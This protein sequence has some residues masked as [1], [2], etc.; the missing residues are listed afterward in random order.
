MQRTETLSLLWFVVAPACLSAGGGGG[1]GVQTACGNGA[2]ESNETTVTCAADCDTGARGTA[3]ANA[4][5]SFGN[6]DGFLSTDSSNNSRPVSGDGSSRA[7]V[8]HLYIVIHG[9]SLNESACYGTSS[10]GPDIDAIALFRKESGQ[11]SLK[12]V[13]KPGSVV[14]KV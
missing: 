1:S 6:A 11:W 4:D 13:G 12:G 10:P 14:H 8:A 7:P 5:S 9:P 2:C 3:G